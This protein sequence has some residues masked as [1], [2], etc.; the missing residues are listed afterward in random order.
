MNQ[1]PAAETDSPDEDA[2]KRRLLSRIAVAAVV[3]VGLLGSLAI[4]DAVYAPA[5]A[6][7]TKVANL[8]PKHEAPPVAEPAKPEAAAVTPETTPAETKPGEPAVTPGAAP[9][10]AAKTEPAAV[11]RTEVKP[12]PEATVAPGAPPLHWGG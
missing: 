5:P 2:L 9:A 12:V 6:P 1:T 7:V 10:G 4:F 3:M 8:P 11:A